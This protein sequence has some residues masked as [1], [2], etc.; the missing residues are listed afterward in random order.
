MTYISVATKSM[1]LQNDLD[2]WAIWHQK[3][4]TSLSHT[5]THMHTFQKKVFKIAAIVYFL[6]HFYLFFLNR[7]PL[8]KHCE[9]A[10]KAVKGH[11]SSQKVMLCLSLAFVSLSP[12]LCLLIKFCFCDN[13]Y[14]TLIVFIWRRAKVTN[15]WLKDLA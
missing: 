13:Y 7:G 3:A 4:K 8:D 6:V 2:V 14:I 5:H 9:L 15:L 10:E 1:F 11:K 12:T